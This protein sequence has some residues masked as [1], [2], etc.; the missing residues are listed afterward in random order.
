MRNGN[1]FIACI[2][3]CLLNGFGNVEIL[4]P[5][6]FKVEGELTDDVRGVWVT[7][8]LAT[9]PCLIAA[10]ATFVAPLALAHTT[11]GTAIHAAGRT[12]RSP[13]NGRCRI[14][15]SGWSHRLVSGEGDDVL[16][17]GIGGWCGD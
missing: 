6:D 2:T 10:L 3:K 8:I 5:L 14:R 11:F 15:K 12:C 1:R 17:R 16:P 7:G 4:D 13:A 9:T